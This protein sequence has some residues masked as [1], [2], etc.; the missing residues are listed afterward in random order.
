MSRVNVWEDNIT[1]TAYL[2]WG[3]TGVV[4]RLNPDGQLTTGMRVPIGASAI[5]G[6]AEWEEAF[7]CGYAEGYDEGKDQGY[8]S[9]YEDG[10]DSV[11]GDW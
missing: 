2:Q 1:E 5:N 11:E 7:N 8:D 10:R 4:F 9:G 3:M 6:N